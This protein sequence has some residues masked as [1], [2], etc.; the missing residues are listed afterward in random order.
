MNSMSKEP[1]FELFQD[2]DEFDCFKINVEWNNRVMPLVNVLKMVETPYLDP[3]ILSGDYGWPAAED[4]YAHLAGDLKDRRW[5]TVA[6]QFEGFWK[7]YN[8]CVHETDNTVVWK[9][10]PASSNK[11]PFGFRE[12]PRYPDFEFDKKSYFESLEAY[13]SQYEEMQRERDEETKE[14]ITSGAKNSEWDRETFDKD[15][16][17]S[18][19]VRPTQEGPIFEVLPDSEVRNC[20][21]AVKIHVEWNGR[22]MPLID[23]LKVWE[24]PFVSPPHT[25]GH[26]DWYPAAYLYQNLVL[27]PQEHPFFRCVLWCDCHNDGCWPFYVEVVE[28]D[29]LVVWTNFRQPHRN[30]F[31][32]DGC[33]D[34]FSYPNFVFEK[35]RY[36]EELERLRPAYEAW[37]KSI[38]KFKVKQRF[39]SISLFR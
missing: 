28:V 21:T 39:A 36:N 20:G 10:L 30:K 34:Y 9:S 29:D 17:F 27:G 16:D 6:Y 11:I 18:S 25:P 37:R 19:V 33:W 4:T 23:V 15:F 13:R 22:R 24:E 3:N 2:Q 35:R 32:A 5:C 38:E 7:E 14:W 1:V 31:S 12:R 26:Y 8:V